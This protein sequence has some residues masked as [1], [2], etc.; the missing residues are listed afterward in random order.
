M[1]MIIIECVCVICSHIIATL[2]EEFEV[3]VEESLVWSVVLAEMLQ[4]HVS[5][6]HYVPHTIVL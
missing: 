4:E 3:S 1:L 2:Q 6:S 5:C